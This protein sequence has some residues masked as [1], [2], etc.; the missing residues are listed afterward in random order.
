MFLLVGAIGPAPVAGRGAEVAA[1]LGEQRE[2]E[3]GLLMARVEV[4]GPLERAL[5]FLPIS[6]RLP[7]HAEQEMGAIRGN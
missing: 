6:R 2:G 7:D 1:A 4:H 5:G 3:Q